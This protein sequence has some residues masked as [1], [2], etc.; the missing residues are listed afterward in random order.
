MP[1]KARGGRV[2]PKGVV[3]LTQ[4][5]VQKPIGGVNA[6]AAPEDDTQPLRPVFKEEG[7]LA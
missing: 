6:I 5:A 3:R 4:G 7:P 1:S 2:R